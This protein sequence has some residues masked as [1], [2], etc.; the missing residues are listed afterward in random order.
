MGLL[1]LPTSKRQ[2]REAKAPAW[3][4]IRSTWEVETQGLL[5]SAVGRNQASLAYGSLGPGGT[6]AG[7]FEIRPGLLRAVGADRV[8]I[9]PVALGER[10]RS[11]GFDLRGKAGQNGQRGGDE[12]GNCDG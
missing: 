9:E 8:I 4:P 11:G 6:Q 3:P 12:R 1:E 5:R 2:K 7:R 10:L